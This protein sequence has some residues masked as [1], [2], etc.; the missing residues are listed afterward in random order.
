MHVNGMS[1]RFFFF[2]TPGIVKQAKW[3]G[4]FGENFLT[5]IKENYKSK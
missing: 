5:G 2:F 1:L 4:R 3:N